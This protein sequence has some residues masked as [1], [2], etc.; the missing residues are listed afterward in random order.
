MPFSA[1]LAAV[2]AGIAILASGHRFLT[3]AEQA[4][5]HEDAAATAG[6]HAVAAHAASGQAARLQTPG[7]DPAW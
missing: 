7:E 2:V 6:E 5:G 4:A 1:G 3:A